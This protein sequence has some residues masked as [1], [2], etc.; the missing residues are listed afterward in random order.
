MYV[1]R[2]VK[3]LFAE[4]KEATKGL[5]TLSGRDCKQRHGET[6]S[7][8]ESSESLKEKIAE[9][10]KRLTEATHAIA[11]KN[12]QWHEKSSIWPE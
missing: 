3:A 2:E 10:E 1:E 12:K 9:L 5:Q 6:M 11:R 8:K 4:Q 7:D